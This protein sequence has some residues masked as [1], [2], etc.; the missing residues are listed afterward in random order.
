MKHFFKANTHY[1]PSLKKLALLVLSLGLALFFMIVSF[2]SCSSTPNTTTTQ[3][4]NVNNN[5]DEETSRRRSS[6]DDDEPDHCDDDE[7]ELCKDDPHCED[8]C[9]IIYAKQDSV[10]SCKNRGDET[11]GMLETVHD[12]LMGENAGY[13]NKFTNRNKKTV[14]T[15][16]KEITE[17]EDDIGHDEL[18]CYLQIGSNKYIKQLKKG[19]AEEDL[20]DDSKK[21][22]AVDRLLETLKWMVED[23]ETTQVLDS[24][25]RGPSIVRALL[26]KLA[27]LRTRRPGNLN[28]QCLI[29][30]GFKDKG[31]KRS[32]SPVYSHRNNR[33]LDQ[34][35]WWFDSD[36]LRIWYYD[37]STS[38]NGREGTIR[39]ID[40]DLYNAL[41]CFHLINNESNNIFTFSAE[42]ENEN[43]FKIAFELLRDISCGS[44]KDS[45]KPG[46]ARALMCWSS[47]Q[48]MCFE[49]TL[50][51][52][53]AGP[54]CAYT[55]N[56][57]H[58]NGEREKSTK[59]LWDEA[60]KHKDELKT[61]EDDNSEY[62]SCDAEDFAEFF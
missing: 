21:E 58:A 44:V 29:N 18:K 42:E 45:Q 14:K 47:W 62:Y 57:K 54:D 13:K 25:N 27:D 30:T 48:K 35:L 61:D 51:A 43:M 39:S 15:D 4:S 22:N 8:T 55:S 38:P 20:N 37:R 46:C 5:D 23:K 10:R 50:N 7:G 52:S 1:I 53:N 9:E 16:L 2:G 12:R 33:Y 26:E 49:R 36:T 11:V 31:A 32:S 41:S 24:I 56:F 40:E 34:A 19:L 6:D 28:E 60:E 59:D 3:G 17:D